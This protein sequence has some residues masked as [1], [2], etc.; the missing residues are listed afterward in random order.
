MGFV[1]T[2]AATERERART[3]ERESLYEGRR[4]GVLPWHRVLPSLAGTAARRP[5]YSQVHGT[6]K[7][8]YWAWM[9]CAGTD[10]QA[11]V[12]LLSLLELSYD[13]TLSV[14]LYHN[15]RPSE[16]AG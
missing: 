7:G 2:R 4:A 16:N 3:S 1:R 14:D 10:I 13:I 11:G 6:G 8:S 15:P 9:W 12:E 5:V